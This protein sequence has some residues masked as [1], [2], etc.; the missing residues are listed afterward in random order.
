MLSPTSMVLELP[1]LML[2][3]TKGAVVDVVPVGTSSN[4]APTAKPVAVEVARRERGAGAP[5]GHAVA[6]E[7]IAGTCL[8]AQ[9]GG[10]AVDDVDAAGIL[11]GGAI[12]A[13]D[14]FERHAD[15]E[16]ADPIPVEVT[17][18]D[19]AAAAVLADLA[20]LPCM[21]PWSVRLAARVLSVLLLAS[22]RVVLVL[23]H[24]AGWPA[25][26]LGRP[27]DRRA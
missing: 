23:Q 20:Q 12:C 14:V 19:A 5:V 27:A 9:A 17:P 8:A 24:F 3:L 4:G 2:L 11:D 25:N 13:G 1:S 7:L 6:E 22:W 18:R 15:G 16:I 21:G 26:S 10:G